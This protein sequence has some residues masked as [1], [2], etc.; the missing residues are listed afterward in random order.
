MIE[1]NELA[2]NLGDLYKDIHAIKINKTD[3]FNTLVKK[4]YLVMEK[5]G[6]CQG[7]WSENGRTFANPEWCMCWHTFKSNVESA[8][9]I[10]YLLSSPPKKLLAY[11]KKPKI[12]K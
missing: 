6:I 2:Q 7:T 8:F 12:K 5:H 11:G 9:N 1:K 3:S 10:M 4:F